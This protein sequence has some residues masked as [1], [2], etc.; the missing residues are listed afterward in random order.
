MPAASDGLLTTTSPISPARYFFVRLAAGWNDHAQIAIDQRPADTDEP[1]ADH[2]VGSDAGRRG[3][4]FSRAVDLH[5][6]R[7]NLFAQA[8]ECG[9]VHWFGSKPD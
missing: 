8:L 1:I 4:Y 9:C 7:A 3:A 2:L 6:V 5:H